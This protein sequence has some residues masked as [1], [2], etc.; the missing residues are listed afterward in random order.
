MISVK[1]RSSLGTET[2][3]RMQ[4][5]YPEA[6]SSANIMGS[7]LTFVFEKKQI[8]KIGKTTAHVEYLI[9]TEFA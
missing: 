1:S 2:G 3:R 5:K 7:K 9:G 8:S 4:S 6:C